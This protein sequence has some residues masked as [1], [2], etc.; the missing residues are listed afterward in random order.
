MNFQ[1]EMFFYDDDEKYLEYLN[2]EHRS[3]FIRVWVD[4]FNKWDDHD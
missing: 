3:C 2:Y 4:N 1:N